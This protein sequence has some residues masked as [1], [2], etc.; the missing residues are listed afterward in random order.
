MFYADYRAGALGPLD[1][2]SGVAYKFTTAQTG[3]LGLAPYLG[4][5]LGCWLAPR[6]MGSVG[7]VR[8][9]VCFTSLAAISCFAHPLFI[10]PFYWVLL[11]II[12]GLSIADC[13]FS[14]RRIG[15]HLTSMGE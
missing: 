12:S 14:G 2:L 8:A 4:F 10:G 5:L 7:H 6:I 1:A 9:F 13:I 3:L 11:R 15:R